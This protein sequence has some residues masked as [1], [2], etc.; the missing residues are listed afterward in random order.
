MKILI[1]GSNGFIGGNLKE[2]FLKK[3]YSVFSPKREQLNLIDKEKIKNYLAENKFDVII[4]S[5]VTLTSI[6]ENLKMYFNFSELNNLYGK[7]ICIGSGAEFDRENYIPKMN[8]DHFGKFIPSK[9]DIY[10]FSKYQIARDII[11]KNIN[12]FNLRVFGIFGKYEDYRRRLISNNICKKLCGNKVSINQ[13]AYFDF[14]YIDDFCKIVE[15]F[16]KANPRDNTYN[17]C[18]GE[19]VDF[20][21][22]INIVN[23]IE[24]NGSEVEVLNKGMGFEYTGDNSRFKNEFGEFDFIKHEK[25]I[26]SLYYWYKNDSGLKFD[27]SIF[28]DWKK[29]NLGKNSI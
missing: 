16:I 10:G 19:K 28:N 21:T 8:E 25:S 13:N 18:T 26:N 11:N 3:A 7:L 17:I 23:N 4:H 6:D 5:A 1:T 20:L 9:D 29:S 14:L 15:K 22:L 2:F 12:I 24:Y 27:D